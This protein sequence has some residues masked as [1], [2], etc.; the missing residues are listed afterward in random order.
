MLT[1]YLTFCCL[2]EFDIEPTQC[3]LAYYITFPSS[4]INPKSV[5][6]YLSGICNQ[7][8]LHFPDV[9]NVHKSPMVSQA[10]KGAKQW[11]GR[12][13]THKLPL[14]ID[15]IDTIFNT[16]DTNP[17]HDNIL[18]TTQLFT[19]FEDLLRLGELCW[20]NKVALHNYCKVTM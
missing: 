9:W 4:H 12:T 8:E 5:N 16:L 20:P 19:G 1:S 13:T 14:T 18:F 7:L 6:S 2:H 17:S 3:T 10:L 11:Y 15:N